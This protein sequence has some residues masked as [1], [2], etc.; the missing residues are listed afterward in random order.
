MFRGAGAPLIIIN[1]SAERDQGHRV[2]QQNI[3]AAKVSICRIQI[4]VARL[5]KD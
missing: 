4:D 2:Q 5:K 3:S 1:K